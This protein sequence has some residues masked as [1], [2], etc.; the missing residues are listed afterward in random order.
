MME[1]TPP[2]QSKMSFLYWGADNVLIHKPVVRPRQTSNSSRKVHCRRLVMGPQQTQNSEPISSIQIQPLTSSTLDS[3]THILDLRAAVR[4]PRQHR[5][6]LRTLKMVTRLQGRPSQPPDRRG[7]AA[8]AL[9]PLHLCRADP[10]RA[11]LRK[12]AA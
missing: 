8:R 12:R 9:S 3:A 11:T 2:I 6:V 10:G 5:V 4:K 7:T 1:M